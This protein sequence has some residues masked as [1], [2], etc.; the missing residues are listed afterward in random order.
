MQKKLMSV[1][2]RGIVIM[3]NSV[4]NVKKTGVRRKNIKK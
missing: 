3:L 1:N 2:D 4:R